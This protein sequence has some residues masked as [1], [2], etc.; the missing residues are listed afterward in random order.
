[1]GAVATLPIGKR[2]ADS[3]DFEPADAVGPCPPEW[4]VRLA[5]LRTNDDDLLL[6]H[7]TRCARCADTFTKT[8]GSLR[9]VR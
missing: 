9:K 7:M 3:Q 5:A 6:A 1:M 4:I 8:L 2:G